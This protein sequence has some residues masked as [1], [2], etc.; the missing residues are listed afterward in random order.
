MVKEAKIADSHVKMGLAAGDGGSLLWPL[1][2][3]FWRAKE[4]LLTG[5]PLTGA[6][7]AELG[8]ISHAVDRE[9]LDEAVFGLADRLA[10]G[11]PKALYGT[12]SAIHHVL[13]RLL[14]PSI[15]MGFNMETIS[16]L[17]ADHA[18]A[19]FAFRDKREP[20]FTGR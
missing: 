15:D 7:A 17:S 10:N 8:L 4:F 1:K 13:K 3:G 5:D 14:D 12:K 6:R 2:M 19:V 9:Q 18:E 20:N 11:A 16:Y